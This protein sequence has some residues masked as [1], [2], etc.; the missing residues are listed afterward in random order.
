MSTLQDAVAEAQEAHS[1]VLEQ[2][3]AAAEERDAAQA[4]AQSVQEQLREEVDAAQAAKEQAKQLLE[5][6]ERLRESLRTCLLYT[7]PSPRD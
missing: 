7:S 3:E 5:E 1:R 6:C 4:E 2:A